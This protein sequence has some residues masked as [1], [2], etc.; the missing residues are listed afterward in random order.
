MVRL[1]NPQLSVMS[2]QE[3]ISKIRFLE[4]QKASA[5]K[6]YFFVMERFHRLNNHVREVVIPED[7]TT[8]FMRQEY[9][10]LKELARELAECPVCLEELTTETTK[11]G[12]C[13]HLVC[14]ICRP[15]ITDCPVCRNRF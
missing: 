10:R 4:N 15:R 1:S 6:A 2:R 11:V 8:D 13:G 3:L 12:F 5:W 7:A 9:I 14:T